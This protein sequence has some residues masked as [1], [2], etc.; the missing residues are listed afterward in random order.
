[1]KPY[2]NIDNNTEQKYFKSTETFTA[3]KYFNRMFHSSQAA[4]TLND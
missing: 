3:L 2:F 1:M 4:I